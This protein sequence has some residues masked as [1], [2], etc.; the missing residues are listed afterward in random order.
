MFTKAVNA[1]S[2]FY[3]F[4]LIPR[5]KNTEGGLPCWHSLVLKKIP[6]WCESFYYFWQLQ[7]FRLN[8]DSLACEMVCTEVSKLSIYSVWF[9]IPEIGVKGNMYEAHLLKTSCN[10]FNEKKK[11]WS[12]KYLRKHEG[13][14]F[15]IFTRRIRRIPLCM[16]FSVLEQQTENLLTTCHLDACQF[17]PFYA[18]CMAWM[19]Q[20]FTPFRICC[21]LVT[22]K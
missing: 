21:G 4:F 6:W 17:V 15:W 19:G 8:I 22:S 5:R 20:S 12:Y 7:E 2:L 1:R 10:W 14:L 13:F 3:L 16:S 9:T 11:H 18:W